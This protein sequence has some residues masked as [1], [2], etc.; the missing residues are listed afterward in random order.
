[1]RCDGWRVFEGFSLIIG[2][3]MPIE[4]AAQRAARTDTSAVTGYGRIF[5]LH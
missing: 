2:G 4:D 3:A 5:Q 1:M